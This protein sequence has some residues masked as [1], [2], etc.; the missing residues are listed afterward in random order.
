MAMYQP[1][2]LTHIGGDDGMDDQQFEEESPAD[3]S[4]GDMVPLAIAA[5]IVVV[6]IA[7][8]VVFIRSR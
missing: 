4:G 8:A 7:A 3:P 1:G 6:G 5:V 2:E